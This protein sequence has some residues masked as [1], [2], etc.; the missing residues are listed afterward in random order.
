[1]EERT[2]LI[3]LLAGLISKAVQPPLTHGDEGDDHER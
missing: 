2:A 3:T 1:M